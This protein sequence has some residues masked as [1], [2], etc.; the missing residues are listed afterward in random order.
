MAQSPKKSSSGR[1]VLEGE[2]RYQA[3]IQ[4]SHEGIWR[5]EVE[6]PI[7]VDLS[8]KEQIKRMY[9][10][11]YL[12]EANNAMAAMYGLKSA[13]QL[14]GARLP[15]MLIESDPRNTEYLLAFI[16]SG[17]SLSGV[18]SHEVDSEGNYKVFR[19]SLVGI[20]EDGKL[21]R[22]WGTQQDITAQTQAQTRLVES[23]ERLSLALQ[24]SRLGMWDK[25]QC[26]DN[27]QKIH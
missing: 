15:E 5:F 13:K 24:A 23:E 22:A 17:Y 4:N 12:A 27:L 2:E 21:V 8:P 3:F 7:P 1:K 26:H 11:S 20:V 25:T 14:V 10:Y 18:D 6:K 16:E 19:N 9:K